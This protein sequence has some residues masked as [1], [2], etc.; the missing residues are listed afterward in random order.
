MVSEIPNFLSDEECEEVIEIAKATGLFG[1][2]LHADSVMEKRQK[3]IKGTLTN[4][5][6]YIIVK[7]SNCMCIVIKLEI[8]VSFN[9]VT[10]L[11]LKSGLRFDILVFTKLKR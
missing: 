3:K 5:L 11:Y 8:I 6:T 7:V 2:Y 9:I 10:R 4:I 1:S